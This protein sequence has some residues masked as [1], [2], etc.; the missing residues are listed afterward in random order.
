[1]VTVSRTR[2]ER[3][4]ATRELILSTA[5]PRRGREET[6]TGLVDAVTAVRLA[7]ATPADGHGRAATTEEERT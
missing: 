6:A 4:G 1:M 7:P 5:D 2:T 3:V